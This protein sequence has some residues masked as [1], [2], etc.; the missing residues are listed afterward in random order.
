MARSTMYLGVV[1]SAVLAVGLGF[2]WPSFVLADEPPAQTTPFTGTGGEAN[3]VPGAQEPASPIP[4]PTVQEEPSSPTEG[5]DIQE[6]GILPGLVAPG[7]SLQITAPTPSLTAIRNAIKVTS[8]SISVNLRIPA[9]L[10][11][12][13]P[14]E[15]SV[16]YISPAQAQR[17]TKTYSPTTGLTLLYRE[18]EGDGKPRAMHLDI[19][20]RELVPNGKSFS[21]S[22][23]FTITPLYRAIISPL[24]F[25]MAT[26]CDTVG[27][28]DI[29]FQW[30]YF[31]GTFS[32]QKFD[33]GFNETK[34]VNHFNS[35]RSEFSTEANLKEPV[36]KFAERDIG[37]YISPLGYSGTTLV[38]GPTKEFSFF[39]DEGAMGPPPKQH[40]GSTKCKAHISYRI[41]RSLMT[42]DQF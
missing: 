15:I 42:F 16:G 22:K 17:Q 18:A 21:V 35:A 14:V 31:D 2:G 10:P 34:M 1:G 36:F 27:K 4:S 11:V 5:I 28:S 37:E 8:K 29:T 41:D 3:T 20:V 13:V 39:L 9:K 23:Q 12:T 7:A 25:L 33:L 40:S 30:R 19:T 24:K 26:Q 6:R 32:E 38:P